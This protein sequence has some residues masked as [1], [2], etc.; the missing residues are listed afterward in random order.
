MHAKSFGSVPVRTDLHISH[1][2]RERPYVFLHLHQGISLD[3]HH[4]AYI[5]ATSFLDDSLVPLHEAIQHVVSPPASHLG[6]QASTLIIIDS[7]SML[8][9]CLKGS[10]EHV[11]QVFVN[12]LRLLRQTCESQDAALLTLMQADACAAKSNR[13][14]L[15]QGDERLFRYLLR[16]ADVWVSVSEL[17]S[18]RAAACDG[19]FGMHALDRPTM[20][21]SSTPSD[22]IYPFLMD[23]YIP[24]STK[25][26]YRILPDG[27]GPKQDDGT[28]A[29][30]R[31][32]S[33]GSGADVI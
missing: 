28:R 27:T 33:R 9:W 26:L 21:R 16:T 11:Y 10:P 23:R 13:G 12:W 20:A 30:V 15:D 29:I 32:W 7:L 8:Q 2:L 1:T 17:P 14:T 6:T 18:G 31:V 24:V 3:T 22:P 4:F 19:E 5:D 25:F